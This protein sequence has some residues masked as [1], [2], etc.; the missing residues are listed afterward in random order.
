MMRWRVAAVSLLIW[1]GSASAQVPGLNRSGLFEDET[2]PEAP[3]G[4]QVVPD[5]AASVQMDLDA[6]FPEGIALG[7]NASAGANTLTVYR[8]GLVEIRTFGSQ[9]GP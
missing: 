1:T 8:A 5:D 7:P 9:L 4:P 3:F 2:A 6:S